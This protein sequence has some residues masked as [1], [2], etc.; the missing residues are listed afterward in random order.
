MKVAL[1][2]GNQ[3]HRDHPALDD[4]S[5]DSIIMIE[6]Q[7]LCRRVPYHKQKLVFMLSAMRHWAD[8][9]QAQGKRVIY[10]NIDKTHNYI[11]EL[12]HIVSEHALSEIAYMRPADKSADSALESFCEKRGLKTTIYPSRLFIT[13]R[14]D[15]E[16][17]FL[18]N[19]K[20]A[21]EV[22][23]RWQRKR[24]GFL[25]DGT[26]PVGGAWNYDHENRK[27]LPKNFSGSP[28]LPEINHDEITKEVIKTIE[29]LYPKNPGIAEGVWLPQ[30]HKDAEKWLDDFIENRLELFGTY[31]DAMATN[32]AFL[33]HSVL[34]PLINSG[35]LSAQVSVEKAMEAYEGGKAP[36]AS[37]EGFV[38][39]IIGWREYMYGM[40]LTMENFGSLNFFGFT[41]ELE[42][43]WYVTDAKEHASLPLPVRQALKRAHMFGYNHH[44]ERLMVLGNW[45]L[46]NG[47]NPMSVY[48]WFSAMYV[49][50]YEWVMVPNVLG[51]SQYAD[52]GRVATKPYISGG[53]YLKK[54]GRWD[55]L[56]EDDL[57]R[58]TNLYWA[59]LKAHKDKLAHNPR[60]AIMF[61]RVI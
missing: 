6:A 5:V 23:Y 14:A 25:M 41:K 55:G 42:D 27:P 17:W 44:I 30:T 61:K 59:F 50:A 29:K 13:P 43:W 19:P 9:A 49:D 28:K 10:R 7:N 4:H 12:G 16:Q 15:L 11:D 54:M 58:F 60:M 56:K 37:V 53:N 8:Y 40:Y 2:L 51:M 3:L 36:L 45:F 20:S 47:Y 34:S 1:V 26:K 33:F 21:M 24:T 35:L 46:L 52:G 31:E 22:F 48:V 38:R 39:Q 32:E 18:Q 57:E